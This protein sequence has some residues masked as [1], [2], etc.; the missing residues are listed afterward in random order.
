MAD[1]ATITAEGLDAL[2]ERLHEVEGYL[3]VAQKRE[4]VE[5]L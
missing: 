3:H 2:E 4:L 1:E 5:A